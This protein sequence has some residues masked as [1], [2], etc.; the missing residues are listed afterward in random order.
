MISPP[1]AFPQECRPGPSLPRQGPWG[2][3]LCC[4]SAPRAFSLCPEGTS[5]SREG[6]EQRL[7]SFAPQPVIPWPS[8]PRQP[9]FPTSA[10]LPAHGNS[11][12]EPNFHL[13]LK[14]QQVPLPG[15]TFTDK[16]FMDLFP[17]HQGEGGSADGDVFYMKFR[18][19]CH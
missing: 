11:W 13:L 5:G 9:C 14:S 16:I 1:R 4:D 19:H 2:A 17:F 8:A 6:P 18:N 15:K 3:P 10:P 12:M 7:L